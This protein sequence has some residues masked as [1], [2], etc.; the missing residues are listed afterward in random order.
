MQ[1]LLATDIVSSTRLWA[2]H[3]S[4]MAVDLATHDELVVAAITRNGG[5][6]FKHTG[7]GMLATFDSATASADAAAEIQRAIGVQTWH[8]PD[9]LQVRLALHSGSVH[10]RDGDLFGPP[11]NRLARLLARC[12][13]GS[14]LVS[15]TSAGLLAGD[16]P[17][18]LEL[19]ELGRIELRDVGS[20]EKV[21]CLVGEH[22]SVNARPPA[23]TGTASR[24]A[25]WTLDRV[26]GLFPR[27]RERMRNRGNALS[28]GEQQMLATGRALVTNP[29]LLLMDE[30]TE[31]LAPLIV[32]E[33][34]R[35][36]TDLRAEGISILLVEQ[37]L[38][39]ALDLADH[40][41]VLSKGTIVHTCTP[42]ELMANDEIKARYLGV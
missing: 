2:E 40:V 13:S 11:V 39:F 23:E 3:E 34:G 21:H 27:L 7:D 9:G 42:A 20:S 41:Y 14:V 12:S 6:V 17:D 15:E 30:P 37:N 28:G 29:D 1:S 25:A 19:R 22:L 18:G 16:M 32:R 31:G 33:L 38:G 10:E 35:I 26:L 5:R 4:A 24:G 8:V 36:L